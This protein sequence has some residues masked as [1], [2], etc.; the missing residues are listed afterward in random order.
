MKSASFVCFSLLAFTTLE[1]PAGQRAA[2]SL[3]DVMNDVMNEALRSWEVPGAALG[4]VKD[5][6]ITMKGFGVRELGKKELVTTNTI[7]PIASCTK[8]FTSLALAM[9]VDDGKLS[10]DDPVNKHVDFF[11]LFDPLANANVTLR[12]LVSHRTGVG[13]HELLWYRAPWGLEERIRK[14]GKVKPARSFREGLEYQSI[15]F[16][17]AGYAAGKAAGTSWEDLVRR[18]VVEPLGMK[19]TSFTTKPAIAAPNH[20]SPHKKNGEKIAVIPWYPIAEP[21]PAGSINSNVRDLIAFI[22][23]QLGDGNWRGKRLVSAE[24]LHETQSPQIVVPLKGYTR[25]M[26]P[27][28]H[29]LSYGMGWVV[30]DYRGRHLLMHGGAIDGFRAHFTLVPEAGLGF[31]LLNNLH[32]THMNLAVSNT[33][34]DHFLGLPYKDWNAFYLDIDRRLDEAG[35]EDRKHFW[36]KR[37]KDTKPSLPLAAYTGTYVEPAYGKAR[38]TLEDGKLVW[39]WSTFHWPLKHYELDKFVASGDG[40]FDV[41][42]F[43]LGHDGSISRVRALGQE[44]RRVGQNEK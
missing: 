5:G 39:H 26:N 6:R 7:F 40:L 31:V 16:G 41:F 28:T 25:V 15:L 37:R 3:D 8:S 24:N 17:T 21:D 33:L 27:A 44:F 20:A 19:H 42:E 38:L 36:D 4:I 18:R 13:P 30:Q 35:K 43:R 2:A 1:V 9:L 32:D 11:Q 22:Q 14:I 12:D 34:V 10:W 29:Q 23:L